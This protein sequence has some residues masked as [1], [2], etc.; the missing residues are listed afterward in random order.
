MPV[1]E[2]TVTAPD[3]RVL[4]YRVEGAPGDPIVVAHHGT[5][6]SRLPLHPDPHVGDGLQVVTYDRPG[7]GGSDPRP[8]RTVA[9]AAADVEAIAD[10]LGLERF[11][12][13]GTSGG[14]PHALACAAL[15][16]AR[17]ARTAILVGVAPMDDP[18]LDFTA[19]M[20]EI[21]THDFELASAD[22]EAFR[23]FLVPDI[24]TIKAD[25]IGFLDQLLTQMPAEDAATL[26]SP[27]MREQLRLHWAEAFAQDEEG[28]YEDTLAFVGPWGFRLEDIACETRLWQGALDTLVPRA[29][30]ARMAARIPNAEFELVPGIGHMI[31]D[32][33]RPALDWLVAS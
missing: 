7:Y 15:L 2:D 14:G 5:P 32:Q 31:F 1:R 22:P 20:A 28:V 27:A 4:A 6:G 18:E 13:M 24:A 8:G 3:G 10:A 9:D 12:V 29:H 30:G 25:P 33:V 16:P 11:C 23:E 19:G 21:N 17:V 26:E